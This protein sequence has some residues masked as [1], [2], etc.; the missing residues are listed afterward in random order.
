MKKQNQLGENLKVFLI[1]LGFLA[2]IMF[3]TW[4]YWFGL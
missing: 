3:L 4:L 1:A 2:L